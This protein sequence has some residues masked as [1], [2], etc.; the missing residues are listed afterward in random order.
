MMAGDG[1]GAGGGGDDDD[2]DD[3]RGGGDRPQGN[4]HN[5]NPPARPPKR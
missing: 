4:Q 5:R 2:D 1:D 3:R